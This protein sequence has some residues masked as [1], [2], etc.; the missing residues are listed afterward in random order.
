MAADGE[1]VR[2]A[3]SIALERTEH[4]DLE[5]QLGQLVGATGGK[6]GSSLAESAA[7]RHDLR[8]EAGAILQRAEAAAQLAALA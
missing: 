2:A 6:R 1:G 8:G 4:G 3:A 5:R 7:H